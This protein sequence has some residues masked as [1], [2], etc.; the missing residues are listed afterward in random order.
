MTLAAPEI[1]CSVI[2]IAGD[3]RYYAFSVAGKK[4]NKPKK[5]GRLAQRRRL[6]R[7]SAADC[8]VPSAATVRDDSR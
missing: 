4:T 7:G 8:Y 6:N 3:V 2:L 1:L 5:N